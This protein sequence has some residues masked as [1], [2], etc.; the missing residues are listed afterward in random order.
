MD[1]K[2]L[3]AQKQS[4]KENANLALNDINHD[5]IV[6]LFAISVY[7]KPA[8]DEDVLSIIIGGPKGKFATIMDKIKDD[9]QERI[10]AAGTKLKK[11][12][13]GM[14][15]DQDGFIILQPR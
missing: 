4:K 9:Y 5:L 11:Q 1:V 8:R 2:A 13:N 10:K 14:M 7:G 12:K 15:I 3:I 6:S